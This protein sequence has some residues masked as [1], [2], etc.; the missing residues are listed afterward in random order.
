MNSVW[1]YPWSLYEEGLEPAIADLNDR[2]VDAVNLASH[3]HSIR[4][5]QP[6]F[7]DALF[8]EYPAGCYFSPDPSRFSETPIDPPENHVGDAQDPVAETVS[9]AADYGIDVHAWTVLFHNTRL[10]VEHPE[11]RIQSA[12]GDAHDH[13][14][15]PSHPQVREYYAAVVKALDARGVTEIQLESL[16]F[17]SAFHD[18]GAE[19]GHDKGQLDLSETESTLL[20]QCFCDACHSAARERGVDLDAARERVRAILSET[21]RDPTVDPPS[22]GDLVQEEPV[23]QE[24]FR[25]R[26]DVVTGLAETLADRVTG[27][28]LSCYVPEFGVDANWPSGRRL[29]ALDDILDR[30]LA[31]CYVSDPDEARDRIGTL[32]RTVASPVDAGVTID[33]SILDGREQFLDLV[34]AIFDEEVDQLAVYNHGFMTETH[35][36]WLREAFRDR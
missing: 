7:P 13:A 25:F 16:C 12:F 3:Y 19:Y 11:F 35:F 1:T 28:R 36:E 27:A 10:G 6:R 14:F 8:A 21:F 20:S 4:A 34:S 32:R 17:Q 29:G 22:L 18:H 31:L 26:G 23:L 9:V 24:L 15:C 30:F 2:G 33:P 5:L